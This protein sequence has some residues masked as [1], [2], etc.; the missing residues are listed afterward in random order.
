[1]NS[2]IVIWLPIVREKLI[3]FRGPRLV[4][5]IELQEM[6][7]RADKDI[8]EGNVFSTD[9]IIEAIERGDI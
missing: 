1:M 6:I 7:K 2:R 3:E 8:E 9:D 4:Q 5:N